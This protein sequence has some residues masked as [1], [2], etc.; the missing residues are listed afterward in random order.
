MGDQC[1]V[2]TRKCRLLEI[3]ECICNIKLSF[4]IGQS[5]FCQSGI[6]EK[7]MNVQSK[8]NFHGPRS[9]PPCVTLRKSYELSRSQF[10]LRWI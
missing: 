1:V 7:V 2:K 5:D 6:V 3:T 8:N 4:F 9:V 10:I